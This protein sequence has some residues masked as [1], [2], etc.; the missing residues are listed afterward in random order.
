MFRLIKDLTEVVSEISEN[1]EP[2]TSNESIKRL[3]EHLSL[4]TYNEYWGIQN[5][6]PERLEEFLDFYER[7]V[8]HAPKEL[9]Y[10]AELILQ[11]AD[12]AMNEYAMFGEEDFPQDRRVLIA[13][14]VQSHHLSFP[15]LLETY[16]GPPSGDSEIE[17]LI[18]NA[19]LDHY[20]QRPL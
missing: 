20:G 6:D 2:T 19:L 12:D 9:E 11:S 18:T 8:P 1:D 17:S 7:Y 15:K 4:T 13:L 10:L 5:S 14:F 16:I 3:S